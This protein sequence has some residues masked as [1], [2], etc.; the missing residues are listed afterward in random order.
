MR[1][2]YFIINMYL[3]KNSIRPET[4][5]E[6]EELT[7]NRLTFALLQW[8]CEIFLLW[9]ENKIT[10]AVWMEKIKKEL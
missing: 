1:V 6:I 4:K 10:Y 3:K 2:G 9:I 5:K 8:K 7:W